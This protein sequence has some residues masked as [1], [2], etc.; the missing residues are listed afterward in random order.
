LIYNG[1]KYKYVLNAGGWALLSTLDFKKDF[2]L[3]CT[4]PDH[5]KYFISAWDGKGVSGD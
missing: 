1:T 4:Y 5:L 2:M 3:A